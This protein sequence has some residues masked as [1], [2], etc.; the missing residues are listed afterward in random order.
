[1]ESADSYFTIKKA[2]YGE[3]KERGSKFLAYAF[4]VTSE[5]ELREELN[6]LKKEH[7]DAVHHCYGMVLGFDSSI[8]KFSD[9]REPSN[10][11]GRP[12]VRTILSHQLTQTAIIVVR[13]FGGK[14]LGVPG[15]IHAYSTAANQA[16]SAAIKEQLYVTETFRIRCRMGQDHDVY[17]ILRQFGARIT[18]QQAGEEIFITFGIRRSLSLKLLEAFRPYHQIQIT[19]YAT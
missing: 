7:F 10:S 19:P 15:L 3:Y 16:L 13:Y 9:D 6:R 12:I 5:L 18:D 14:L 4:P 11:A 1:M 2:A 8:Q 17:R